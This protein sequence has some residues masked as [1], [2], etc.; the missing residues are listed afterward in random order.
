MPERKN[1]PICGVQSPGGRS[2]RYHVRKRERHARE[3]ERWRVVQTW[4]RALSDFIDE[5]REQ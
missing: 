4:V 3:V 2:C 1:C 5:A